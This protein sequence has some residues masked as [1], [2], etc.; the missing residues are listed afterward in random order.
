MPCSP[1]QRG[2]HDRESERDALAVPR[3]TI[4]QASVP[5][6]LWYSDGEMPDDVHEAIRC[7]RVDDRKNRA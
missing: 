1:S 4:G 5:R 6:V 7:A 2:T 3:A